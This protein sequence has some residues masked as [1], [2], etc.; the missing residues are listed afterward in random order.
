MSVPLKNTLPSDQTTLLMEA[1]DHQSV[2][3][4]EKQLALGALLDA[5]C[6]CPDFEYEYTE[7][8][9]DGP[10]GWRP[11][12]RAVFKHRP[13]VVECLLQH[14]ADVN[15]C[16][17]KK[18]NY[19]AIRLAVRAHKDVMKD[20]KQD[21]AGKGYYKRYYRGLLRDF[22]HIIRLLLEH[23]AD[24]CGVA[25]HRIVRKQLAQVR[26]GKVRWAVRVRP[27]SLHWIEAHA[28]ARYKEPDTTAWQALTR[29]LDA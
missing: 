7:P 22:T 10:Y 13:R 3:V 4:V 26:W 17:F 19:S 9:C 25:N 27:F 18:R 15:S 21:K 5:P 16:S 12:Q 2:D 24:C 1:I 29:L 6:I 11:L 28:K 20:L 8:S 14:G 23:G